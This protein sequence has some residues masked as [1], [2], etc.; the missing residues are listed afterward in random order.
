MLNYRLKDKELSKKEQLKVAFTQILTSVVE[1]V[2]T[3]DKFGYRTRESM[4]EDNIN[5][6]LKE[7]SI[8]TD[9]R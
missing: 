6:L 5:L 2:D 3:D 4:I 8:R 1:E 7:V 9:L